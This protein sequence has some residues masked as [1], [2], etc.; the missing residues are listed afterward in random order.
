[1]V[2]ESLSLLQPGSDTS[3]CRVVDA[4][5][6]TVVAADEMVPQAESRFQSVHVVE[7]DAEWECQGE[8]SIL[9]TPWRKKE[10]AAGDITAGGGTTMMVVLDGIVVNRAVVVEGRGCGPGS[11]GRRER[12]RGFRG[13]GMGMG[14]SA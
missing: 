8:F 6:E 3:S 2:V 14:G 7:M 13:G 4:A 9:G 10:G 1:M 11:D 12:R 5:V